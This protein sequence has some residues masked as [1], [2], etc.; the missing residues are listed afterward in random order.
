MCGIEKPGVINIVPKKTVVVLGA[1]AIFFEPIMM[2]LDE[3]GCCY[4]KRKELR[5]GK[6]K[7]ASLKYEKIW[8]HV[9]SIVEQWFRVKERRRELAR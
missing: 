2:N 9:S 7:L 4:V 5:I 6:L 1:V 8:F 3:S